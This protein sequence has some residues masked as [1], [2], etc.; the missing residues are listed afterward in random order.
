MVK[1]SSFLFLKPTRVIHMENVKQCPKHSK[2]YIAFFG[3]SYYKLN[4]FYFSEWLY[5]HQIHQEQSEV[6]T[7]DFLIY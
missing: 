4:C 1:N 7:E 5:W 6:C 3:K 2:P